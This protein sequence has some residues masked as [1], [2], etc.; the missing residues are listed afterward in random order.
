[1][2]SFINT[3]ADVL[4]VIIKYITTGTKAATMLMGLYATFLPAEVSTVIVGCIGVLVF[5]GI[6][7]L[8]EKVVS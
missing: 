7:R 3:V 2:I 8:K 4:A 5:N 6:L 1:M